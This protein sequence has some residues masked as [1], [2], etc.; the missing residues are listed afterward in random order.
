[1]S[2]SSDSYY[3]CLDQMPGRPRRWHD[4]RRAKMRAKRRNSKVHGMNQWR[5]TEPLEVQRENQRAPFV[6]FQDSNGVKGDQ[7]MIKLRFDRD[8]LKLFSCLLWLAG[9][10]RAR[11][12]ISRSGPCIVSTSLACGQAHTLVV[13]KHITSCIFKNNKAQSTTNE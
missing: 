2:H 11:R 10:S 9:N 13:L 3:A 5:N 8:L 7:N 4:S 1:M 6:T 12:W